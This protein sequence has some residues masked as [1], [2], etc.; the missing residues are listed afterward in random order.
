MPI[1]SEPVAGVWLESCR[2]FKF[3][4]K[5][6]LAH[7][8]G[9]GMADLGSSMGIA[10]FSSSGFGEDG[11]TVPGDFTCFS[12]FLLFGG[13]FRRRRAGRA[14]V[15][16]ILH[17]EVSW[18]VQRGRKDEGGGGSGRGVWFAEM[19]KRIAILAAMC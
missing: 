18:R 5:K 3:S 10:G 12:A 6:F 15:Q 11:G 4:S 9:S 17:A 19:R 14:R 2:G 1:W 16:V 8:E 7:S 13:I